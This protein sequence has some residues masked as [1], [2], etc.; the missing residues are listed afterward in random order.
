MS[1]VFTPGFSV[2]QGATLSVQNYSTTHH[3]A[4]NTNGGSSGIPYLASLALVFDGFL[5]VGDS[6][7][8]V[9]D[10]VLHVV[11]DSVNHL[12]LKKPHGRQNLT[13]TAPCQPFDG[14]H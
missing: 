1:K 10:G 8:H 2:Q 12:A 4:H 5:G 11:L 3:L 6:S 13:R 9:V 7:L 14:L